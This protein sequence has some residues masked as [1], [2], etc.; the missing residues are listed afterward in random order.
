ME[1]TL[2]VGEYFLADATYYRSRAPSRGEVAVYLH[3]KQPHLH[4]I[5]R[6]VAVE[7]DRIAIKG[8]RAIVNGMIVEEPYVDA[9]VSDGRFA[10]MPELRVPPGHVYVL[11]DNRAHSVDSRDMVAHGPVPV[12]QS[13]R[14]RDRYR[15][16]APFARAW[17]AGSER[18]AIFI[19]AAPRFV[20]PRALP[21]S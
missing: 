7:G 21:Q 12:A 20:Q 17:A 11:G 2:R 14:T 3:P 13:D 6:I 15:D 9:A 18:R 19:K 4:Y 1:P 16:L 5:K 10:D 8:G